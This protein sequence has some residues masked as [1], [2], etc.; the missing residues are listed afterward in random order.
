MTDV[1]FKDI[2]VLPGQLELKGDNA[3]TLADLVHQLQS[4]SIL[5]GLVVGT[6]AKSEIIFHTSIGRFISPNPLGLVRGD[7]ITI[8]LANEGEEVLGTII[9]I[10]QEIPEIKTPINLAFV[11]DS[12][13]KDSKASRHNKNA[14]VTSFSSVKSASLPETIRGNI[15]YFN[16]NKIDSGSLLYKTLLNNFNPD[17]NQNTI[18]FRI[19]PKSDMIGGQLQISAEVLEASEDSKTQM[20]RTAF[21]IVKTENMNLQKGQILSL[22]ILQINDHQIEK[23]AKSQLTEFIIKLNSS[24]DILKKMNIKETFTQKDSSIQTSNLKAQST[25]TNILNTNLNDRSATT[26]I[27]NSGINNN[28]SKPSNT[29]QS[30][31]HSASQQFTNSTQ[32]SDTT[33]PST[34][35]S[36]TGTAD[37]TNKSI[38]A[39]KVDEIIVNARGA[40]GSSKI[41]EE[42][43]KSGILASNLRI[44][45]RKL[46]QNQEIDPN[47]QEDSYETEVRKDGTVVSKV[48]KYQVRGLNSFLKNLSDMESVKKL[49]TDLVSL[50]ETFISI[51]AVAHDPDNWISVFIPLYNPK[52]VYEQ[53][54]QINYPRNNVMRF[55]INTNFEILG[56]LQ[57]DGLIKY[58]QSLE[59]PTSFD[60]IVR[61][62]EKLDSNIQRNINRI[63]IANQ[64]ITGIKGM[65]Q[66][67]EDEEF[68]QSK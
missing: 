48:G 50:K 13:K 55:L 9:K 24:M 32:L 68:K 47:K 33:N 29:P 22:E 62:K 25:T 61:S 58:N 18:E 56:E 15:S 17:N 57:L 59:H 63:Y 37:N 60:L 30:Q 5:K 45:T 4:S 53:E 41:V 64:E 49:A 3:K 44:G 36:G 31:G 6:T 38:N 42:F 43:V 67:D 35:P 40:E 7:T 10:N 46:K 28:P 16:L 20:I 39:N 54:V 1:N 21:G 23:S 65:I 52:E 8:R 19:L 14:S 2:R 12:G 66:F 11:R 51:S 34:K 26:Q 27:I